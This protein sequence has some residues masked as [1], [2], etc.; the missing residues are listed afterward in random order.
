MVSSLATT[1]FTILCGALYACSTPLSSR[2]VESGHGILSAPTSGIVVAQGSSFPFEF[3]DSNWCE[4]GY[5]PIAVWLTDYAPSASSL[6]STGQFAEGGYTY[7][8]GSYLIPN[9]G[10]PVLS[11]SIPPP[12]SLVFP[13]SSDLSVGDEVYLAVVETG[14]NCPPGLNVPPQYELSAISMTVG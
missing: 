13:V 8:F 9:F 12:S 3:R 6:N 14:N 10:L 7:Y 4:D 5:S 1:V 11:G 2:Q